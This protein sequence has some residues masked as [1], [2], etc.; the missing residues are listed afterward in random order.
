MSIKAV[1][2][3]SG[4][5]LF[6]PEAQEQRAPSCVWWGSVTG[7]EPPGPAGSPV[8]SS[9]PTHPSAFGPSLHPR[10]WHILHPAHTPLSQVCRAETWPASSPQPGSAAQPWCLPGPRNLWSF[11]AWLPQDRPGAAPN[12][13]VHLGPAPIRRSPT[14]LPQTQ[15]AVEASPQP[16]QPGCAEE[17]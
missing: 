6:I 9:W 8:W 5:G 11:H 10:P 3:R 15:A 16:P 12:S 7:R 17:P 2:T 1:L 13:A 4:V 14:F